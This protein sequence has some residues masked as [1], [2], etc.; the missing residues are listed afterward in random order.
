MTADNELL[1][2]ITQTAALFGEDGASGEWTLLYEQWVEIME[3]PET[4]LVN[5]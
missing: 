5:N 2:L 3:L 4:G 1:T